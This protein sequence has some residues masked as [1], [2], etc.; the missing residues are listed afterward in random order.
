MVGVDVVAVYFPMGAAYIDLYW[1]Y[2][3]IHIFYVLVL[4]RRSTVCRFVVRF[5]G[6]EYVVHR[7][8]YNE[9]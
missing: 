4:L 6:S 2:K 8:K 1:S 5:P 9:N 3:C 7:V